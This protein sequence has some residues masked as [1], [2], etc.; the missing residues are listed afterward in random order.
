MS[1]RDEAIEAVVRVFRDDM[2][3][4]KPQAPWEGSIG[5]Y[6]GWTTEQTAAAVV[7]AV[8]PIIRA[9]EREKRA[10]AGIEAELRERI[11]QEI[12]AARNA[13]WQQHLSEHPGADGKSCPRD[14]GIH[15]AFYRA[16]RIARGGE[17]DGVAEATGRFI[18]R[19]V[20]T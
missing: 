6:F 12:E 3:R 10:T 15:D 1:G 8:E 17:S 18:P 14:Y 9:D 13:H 2:P 7:D 4:V 19:G 5:N 11:A 16:A 20:A